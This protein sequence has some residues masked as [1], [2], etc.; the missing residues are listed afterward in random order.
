MIYICVCVVFV[1]QKDLE[2]SKTTKKRGVGEIALSIS[3]GGNIRNHFVWLKRSGQNYI[4]KCQSILIIT[5]ALF[6]I[7]TENTCLLL[8]NCRI[9]ILMNCNHS[10][11]KYYPVLL[12]LRQFE[13]KSIRGFKNTFG[14]KKIKTSK[15]KKKDI[16]HRCLKNC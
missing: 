16:S 6:N 8:G 15:K 5:D 3:I 1:D 4:T 10:S 7:D 12:N 9:T 11:S 2:N 14:I 13:V